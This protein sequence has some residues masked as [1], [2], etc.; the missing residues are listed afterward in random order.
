MTDPYEREFGRRYDT[1]D[2]VTMPLLQR[3]TVQAL[4][5]DYAH[6]ALRHR[7]P[8]PGER[9]GVSWWTWLAV[10]VL[11]GALLAVAGLQTSQAAV[12][13]QSSRATLISRIDAERDV[14]ADTQ[15]R[16]GRLEASL[17]QLQRENDRL[18]GLLDEDVEETRRVGVRTGY[19]A[20]TGPGVR[21][22]VANPPGVD[23]ADAVRDEDLALLVNGLWT[24]G[25]EA[26]AI[27]GQRL[28]ALSYIQNSGRAINVNSR[29]LLPPYVVEAIG[30][31][32]TMQARFMESPSGARFSDLAR[33][34][35]FEVERQNVE[36]L[37][38]PG[39]R[40]RQLRYAESGEAGNV[41]ERGEEGGG[42]A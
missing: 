42:T 14:L 12:D 3:I 13:S 40:S 31:N 27:N 26:V 23:P 25:A 22:T 30:D 18:A 17:S 36:R 16:V 33:V 20:V 9:R 15:A 21:F 19:V 32:R 7:D 6:V 38:L 35:G 2:R 39:A 5:E 24:A 11:V 10:T 4:D 41:P 37:A 1:V 34:L 28:T 8:R 29:P